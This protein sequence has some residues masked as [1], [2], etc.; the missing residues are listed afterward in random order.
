MISVFFQTFAE[1]PK[2]SHDDGEAVIHIIATNDKGDVFVE[3]VVPPT[4]EFHV[5]EGAIDSVG[6]ADCIQKHE[7]RAAGKWNYQAF[8]L[9]CGDTKLALADM[10]M[11]TKR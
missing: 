7:V 5:E 2:Q 6:V 3:P 1:P 10:D 9:V 4:L 11:R 8:V